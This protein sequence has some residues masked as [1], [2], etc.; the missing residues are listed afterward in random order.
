[1]SAPA[2]SRGVC[3]RARRRCAACRRRLS[4]RRWAACCREVTPRF[5]RRDRPKHSVLCLDQWVQPQGYRRVR[6][7]FPGT[8]SCVGVCVRVRVCVH[9]QPWYTV[10]RRL[11][12]VAYLPSGR[13]ECSAQ[14]GSCAQCSTLARRPAPPAATAR[15][16][17]T[18]ATLPPRRWRSGTRLPCS[19]A[20]T[21]RPARPGALA[22]CCVR[23]V[24]PVTGLASLLQRLP[25]VARH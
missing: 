1:M 2:C 23:P 20:R 14:S 25:R 21:R 17:A 10:P 9:V 8:G 6:A 13:C 22:T 16:T 12:L 15:C 5:A 7:P 11:I 18:A 3:R 4:C 24:V 19:A